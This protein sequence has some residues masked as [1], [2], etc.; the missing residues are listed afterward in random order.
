[1][2]ASSGPATRRLTAT[3][4]TLHLT[5]PADDLVDALL[6]ALQRWASAR[7]AGP[8]VAHLEVGDGD[9]SDWFPLTA[10]KVAELT[11]LL[12]GDRAGPPD[13]LVDA[14]LSALQR[15]ASARAAGPPVAHL[16]VGDGDIS[17]WFPLT[18][19][20]VAELTALLAGDRAGPKGAC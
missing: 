4:S 15:W 18:A 11:A 13:D 6:S 1:M 9:I 20:K 14:L 7:A 8:P 19:A 5:G 2:T 3:S 12:A 16:E 17:D 10:A